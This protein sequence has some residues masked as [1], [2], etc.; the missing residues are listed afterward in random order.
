MLGL[1][2]LADQPLELGVGGVQ[3][4]FV[5]STTTDGSGNYNFTNLVPGDYIVKF[6]A[7]DGSVLSTV[8][9]GNDALD[10]DADGV[11]GLTGCYELSAGEVETS[12]D[13]GFYKLASL[14][15][16]VWSDNNA[17]GQQD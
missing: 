15:D 3:G 9:V 17:D 1:A 14:G 11:T 6:I 7:A 5:A 8:D 4:A 10:S 2:Q 12:V 13:A 16:Y